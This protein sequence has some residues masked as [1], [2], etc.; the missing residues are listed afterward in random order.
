MKRLRDFTAGTRIVLPSGRDIIVLA[1]NGIE[2]RDAIRE[3]APSVPW[4][5][6]WVEQLKVK[7]PKP[8]GK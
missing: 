3:I 8:A 2:L 4:H 5:P 6:Q 7:R 1:I